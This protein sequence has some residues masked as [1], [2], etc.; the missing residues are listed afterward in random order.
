MHL[1]GW[2]PEGVD[3]ARPRAAPWNTVWKHRRY[4]HTPWNARPGGLLLGYTATGTREIRDGIRRLGQAL[5][6]LAPAA[7]A[8]R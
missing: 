1:V 6:E 7:A 4:R 2:L 3:D 5:R 8:T